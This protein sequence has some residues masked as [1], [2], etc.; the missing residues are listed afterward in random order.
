M[1]RGFTGQAL[2]HHRKVCIDIDSIFDFTE[3]LLFIGI[4]IREISK[5][6]T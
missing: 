3:F 1:E 5:N 6:Y 2:L 4:I